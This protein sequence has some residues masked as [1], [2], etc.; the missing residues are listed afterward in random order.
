MTT[1]VCVAY[2]I[3]LL[4]K[5]KYTHI[6]VSGNKA[7]VRFLVTINM[8]FQHVV[9]HC[10]KEFVVKVRR[11]KGIHSHE[12][13]TRETKIAKHQILYFISPDKSSKYDVKIFVL[14]L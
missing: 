8:T 5:T 12:R 4:C 14:T 10:V 11:R 6:T 1:L 3:L 2:T 13:F 7:T 9:Q